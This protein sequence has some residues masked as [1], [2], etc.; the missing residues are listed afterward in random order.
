MKGIWV[1]YLLAFSMA[2][3]PGSLWTCSLSRDTQQLQIIPPLQRS[4]GFPPS[5]TQEILSPQSNLFWLYQQVCGIT[6]KQG[7]VRRYYSAMYT[8]T[9]DYVSTAEDQRFSPPSR[10][11]LIYK[12]LWIIMVNK[13]P[14]YFI[15]TKY[16]SWTKLSNYSSFQ[17]RSRFSVSTS[18]W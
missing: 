12:S 13:Q 2:P 4:R 10:T 1:L 17:K 7:M 5:R 6:V 18:W 9:L 14:W 3:M 8:T 16:D 11:L 15:I